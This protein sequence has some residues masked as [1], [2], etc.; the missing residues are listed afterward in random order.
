MIALLRAF[1]YTGGEW[2]IYILIFCSI[3]ALAVIVERGIVLFRENKYLDQVKD[4]FPNFHS[5]VERSQIQKLTEDINQLQGLSARVIGTGLHHLI[6]GSGGIEE[7]TQS[8]ASHEK[9]RLEVRMIILGTLGNNSIYIGLF[10]TVLG[11]IKAFR[12]LAQ[13]TNAGPEVVMQGLS[14]ALIATA[15][16]LMVALPCVIAYNIFQKQIGDLI[17]ETESMVQVILAQQKQGKS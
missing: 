16:G 13:E 10:G 4:I 1:A 6:Q 7:Y 2:V 17:S 5:S 12:D 14:Q 8:V 9:R 15:V 11:V 3:L